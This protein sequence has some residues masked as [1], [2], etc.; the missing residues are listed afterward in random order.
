MTSQLNHVIAQQR[1]TELARC[2]DR[3]RLANQARPSRSASSPRWNLGRL[4]ATPRLKTAPMAAAARR[5]NPEQ[6][7]ECFTCET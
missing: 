2:A 1:Y 5:S 3:A 6:A 4:L 7:Q